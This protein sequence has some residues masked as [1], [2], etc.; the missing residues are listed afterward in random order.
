MLQANFVM[1]VEHKQ[2]VCEVVLPENSPVLCATG[3]PSSRKSI[4]KRSAAFEACLLLRQ[5]DHLD[6]NLIPKYSKRL[7]A[8][9]NAHLALSMKQSNSYTMMTKPSLWEKTRGTRPDELYM[10]VLELETP[11]NLGRPCQPLALLT[12]TRMPDFPPILL[13]LQV[14]K[15]S[16]LIC[17]SLTKSF[18]LSETSLEELNTFTLR[19]YHD[20]FNKKFEDNVAEMSYWIAPVID[21][22]KIDPEYSS[23]ESL[24]DW[25]I[26]RE[27]YCNKELQWDMSKPHSY[28]ANRY[29]V[30]KW[31][32]GRRFFSVGVVPNMRPQDPVP[33]DAAVHKYMTSIIDYSV[34]LFKKS[35]EKAKWNLDQPVLLAHRILHRLNWLDEFTGKESEGKTTSYVCPEPLLISA[36]STKA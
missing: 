34:T 26:I 20:I 5:G 1:S 29:L 23:P 27:V 15:S 12:R 14:K 32:G 31:D 8:M 2:Y 10:T 28:L 33:P 25:S 24:I 3:R 13:Y 35:R 7:P 6:S 9:R 17:T 36:V 16:L 4:A 19:I 11:E 21:H 30:D 18:K 22:P